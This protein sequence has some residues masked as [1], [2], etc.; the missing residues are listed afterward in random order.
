MKWYNYLNIA[1]RAL[2]RNKTRAFLT[3]LGIIIGIASVI[4]VIS[5]GAASTN[6]IRAEIASTGTNMIFINPAQQS[7]GGINMGRDDA[8]S[9]TEK[10]VEALRSKCQY[11]TAVS[12][13]V[14]V[15]G[16][17]VYGTNNAP[18]SLQGV[19]IPFREIR[20]I[21]LDKGIFFSQHD[22]ETA[23]KVCLIGKTVVDK[24]FP[25]GEDPI[26]KYIRFKNIPLRIIGVLEEKGQNSMGM[27]QDNIVYLPYTTVQKR[28]LAITHF[29]TIYASAT[30]EEDSELAVAEI[31][32]IMR[33][34]HKLQPA[35]EE[36]FEIF[37]QAEMLSMISSVTGMLTAL[38]AAVAAI[39]LLVGGI[40]IMNIM[41]VTV[42]ER[43]KEIGLRMSIGARKQY[44]LVQFLTESV[45]LSLI[46]GL[47][48]VFLGIIVSYIGS[49]FLGW[50][51]VLNFGSI[52]LAFGVCFFEGVFFGW[53]PA[54]KASQLDPIVALRYE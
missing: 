22:V 19:D 49:F 11:V 47:L 18:T 8:K 23:S 42:T 45:I 30:S 50:D 5:L 48:G 37:T 33:M 6:N 28:M 26:G 54:R 15:S 31:T 14:S 21:K 25:G 24:L 36:D 41:Y 34:S 10:D 20:D 39:S 43:T 46:G 44:V 53:Y 38:L 35:D 13:S 1:Y 32:K 7:R 40:G 27:D 17:L 51:F 29:N 9:L 4:A 52:L 16:Q 12:P 3:M 2:M